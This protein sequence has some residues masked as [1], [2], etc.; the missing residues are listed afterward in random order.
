MVWVL[1]ML[2]QY[3]TLARHYVTLDGERPSDEWIIALL[4]LRTRPIPVP[5]GFATNA[6][7]S[8]A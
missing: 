5:A 1:L 7:R 4:K 3:K 8:A 6:E 2:K